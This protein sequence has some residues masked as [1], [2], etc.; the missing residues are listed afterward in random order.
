VLF[1]FVENILLLYWETLIYL[2]LTGL[3]PLVM[4]VLVMIIFWITA[5]ANHYNGRRENIRIHNIPES[6]SEDDDG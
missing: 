4:E 6:N 1:N 3:F 5:S 2:A